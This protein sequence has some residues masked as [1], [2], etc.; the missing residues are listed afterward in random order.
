M[1][2]GIGIL[3]SDGEFMDLTP[4]LILAP[5]VLVELS[6]A[7]P[8]FGSGKPAYQFHQSKSQSK[9]VKISIGKPAYQENM[10]GQFCHKSCIFDENNGKIKN[11]QTDQH[12]FT[13][14][15]ESF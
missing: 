14:H 1:N 4:S 9:W 2:D 13:D 8:G 10:S 5:P 6:S 12:Q 11:G 15:P 7:Y 3:Y